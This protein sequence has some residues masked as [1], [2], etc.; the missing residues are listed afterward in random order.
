MSSASPTGLIDSPELYSVVIPDTASPAESEAAA[1]VSNCIAKATGVTL[2][3]LSLPRAGACPECAFILGDVGLLP[4]DLIPAR[5]AQND[6][7]YI[8]CRRGTRVYLTGKTPGGTRNGAVSLVKDF[9]GF[10]FLTD[11]CEV[12]L[13][14]R[15]R[16]IPDGLTISKSPVFEFRNSYYWFVRQSP[17]YNAY[18]RLRGVRYAGG[19]VHTLYALAEMTGDPIGNQPCMTDEN[20][21]RTVRKNVVSLLRAH[22]DATVVSVSQNDSYEPQLGCQCEA[23]R[24]LNKK[25]GTEGGALFAFVNRLAADLET[26]YPHVL[27]ETLAYRYTS[28]PPK[29]MT[30][31]KNVMVEICLMDACY[32]HVLD[33]PACPQNM[34]Y[35]RSLDVWSKICSRLSVWDYHTDFAYYQAIFP[36]YHILY[37]HIRYYAAHSVVS[38]FNEGNHNSLSSQLEELRSYLCSELMW[39]IDM[40]RE[41][42]D[43]HMNEFLSLYYGPG[44]TCI[45]E[46]IDRTEALAATGGRHYSLYARPHDILPL[47]MNSPA[48]TA[49]ADELVTLFAKALGMAE[50]DE[51]RQRIVKASI[52]PRYFRQLTD[53]RPD[54]APA[55]LSLYQDMVSSGITH[56]TEGG[57]FPSPERAKEAPGK[58]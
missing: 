36:N 7:G 12:L 30:F 21:Y 11:D 45:R 19:M 8:L 22:P 40:S 49:V 48:G 23:C 27:I 14:D 1:L 44:W 46:F 3:V 18:H 42:Y 25:Y 50:T 58:W 16:P 34:R 47:D 15:V 26:E 53:E 32:T 39:D 2:P 52:S 10:R 33:D 9:L 24:A 35:A 54:T 29:A 5:D 20:V 41:T 13:P 57:G 4:D 6:D 28:V 31:H 56:I 38:V 55:N 43:A 17:T 37:D 51:Q